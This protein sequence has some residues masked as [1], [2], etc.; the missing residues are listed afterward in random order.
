MERLTKGNGNSKAPSISILK[1]NP[2][3]SSS[4][5]PCDSLSFTTDIHPHEPGVYSLKVR[6]VVVLSLGKANHVEI[7]NEYGE[8]CGYLATGGAV[9]RLILCMQKG[10]KYKA[11]ISGII[12]NRYEISI[13]PMR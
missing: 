2:Q 11:L 13:S 6:D 10:N 4:E 5:D 1:A 3:F 7:Y 9:A 8:L 12:N